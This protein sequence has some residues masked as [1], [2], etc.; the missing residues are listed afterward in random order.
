MRRR[1]RVWTR[2]AGNAVLGL[3]IRRALAVVGLTGQP[4]LG[5]A[6]IRP[7]QQEALVVSCIKPLAGSCSK[8]YV[9][10]APFSIDLQRLDQLDD[11]A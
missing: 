1:S 11:P 7:A 4:V 2:R 3:F 8:S 5:V 10:V 6:Q 9:L